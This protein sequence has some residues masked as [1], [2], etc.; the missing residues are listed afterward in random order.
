MNDHATWL[1]HLYWL[2]TLALPSDVPVAAAVVDQHGTC[3]GSAYNEREH[4]QQT[5]AHAEI[6][7]I[8]RANRHLNN[9]RLHGC[10]LYVTLEPCMMC[11]GAIIDSHISQVVF[12]SY[13]TIGGS[14]ALL[15][16]HNIHVI[17]GIGELPYTKLLTD[18]FV[19]MRSVKN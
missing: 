7:A 10:T 19:E 16:D 6:L 3:L 4:T 13:N 12:S 9:W 2:A 18:F 15:R 14:S 1:R 5:I 8:G 17:S 11:A